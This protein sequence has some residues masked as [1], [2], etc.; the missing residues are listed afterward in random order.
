MRHNRIYGRCR[1]GGVAR[2][3]EFCVLLRR[4]DTFLADVF[5]SVLQP[6]PPI[7]Y[8]VHTPLPCEERLRYHLNDTFLA[9][10]F[11]SEP[12]PLPSAEHVVQTP[13]TGGKSEL[14]VQQ[15]APT[16]SRVNTMAICGAVAHH[17]KPCKE[18]SPFEATL[19]RHNQANNNNIPALCSIQKVLQMFPQRVGADHH[20]QTCF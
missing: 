11:T 12:S 16:V 6:L 13:T 20:L 4:N 14:A 2:S 9:D 8:V 17:V 7:K 1:T 15:H 10:I 3:Q 18:T 19:G 5:T